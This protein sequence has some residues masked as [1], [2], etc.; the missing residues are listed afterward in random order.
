[1]AYYCWR[2][3]DVRRTTSAG[4]L[5]GLRILWGVAGFEAMSGD[6]FCS[7][8]DPNLEKMKRPLKH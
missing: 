8:T 2:L 4:R 7:C 1:M 5:G 3:G 6:D